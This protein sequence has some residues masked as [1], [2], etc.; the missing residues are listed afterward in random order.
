MKN[1]KKLMCEYGRTL[2]FNQ[3][4]LRHKSLRLLIELINSNLSYLLV[5]SLNCVEERIQNKYTYTKILI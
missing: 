5:G 4:I 1:G 3:K 2:S